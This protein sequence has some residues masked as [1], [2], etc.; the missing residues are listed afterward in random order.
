MNT[1]EWHKTGLFFG[2]FNPVHIGHMILASYFLEHTPI[3]D[4]QLILSPQN[5]F[6]PI[7]SLASE[8]HRLKMLELA[9]AAYPDL[10]IGINTIE[11]NLPKPSYTI[12]TLTELQQKNPN[13][14]YLLLMGADSLANIGVWRDHEKILSGFEIYAYPRI[15]YDLQELCKKLG[16]V[17]L[18]APSIEISATF[19]R[20]EIENKHNTSAYFPYGVWSYIKENKLYT[21][22]EK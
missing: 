19:L 16:A 15:G 2:S 22:T 5:P 12:T 7:S 13:T 4:L 9:V 21:K 17:P 20:K 1:Q 11:L 3:D 18:A 8:Q 10:P 14:T 6:K